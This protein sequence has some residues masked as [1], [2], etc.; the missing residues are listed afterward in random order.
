MAST[1]KAVVVS[2]GGSGSGSSGALDQ[3]VFTFIFGILQPV[4][5]GN[6]TNYVSA[7][8]VLRITHWRITAVT[9]PTGSGNLIVDIRKNGTSILQTLDTNKIKLTGGS[10][11]N[12]GTNFLATPTNLAIGDKLQ[13]H[14]IAI[15]GTFPGAYIAVQLVGKVA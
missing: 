4:V 1:R 10:G 6:F 9:V 7:E 8:A 12:E 13:G 14:I 5:V 15:T 3:V 11:S 2:G